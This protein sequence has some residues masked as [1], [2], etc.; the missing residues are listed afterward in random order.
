MKSKDLDNAFTSL[1]RLQ[2]MQSLA[3]AA[4]NDIDKH[5]HIIDYADAISE[6]VT[7]L[8]ASL[9]GIERSLAA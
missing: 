9:E 6:L 2:F 5:Y 7:Q 3:F 4:Q 8:Q 1:H